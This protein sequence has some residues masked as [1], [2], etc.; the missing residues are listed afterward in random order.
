MEIKSATAA[1]ETEWT[2]DNQDLGTDSRDKED[3]TPQEN[4]HPKAYKRPAFLHIAGPAQAINMDDI[5][6]LTVGTIR[7][8]VDLQRKVKNVVTFLDRVVWAI[9]KHKVLRDTLQADSPSQELKRLVD[10]CF[11]A[12]GRRNECGQ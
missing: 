1:R 10:D 2:A 5:V 9:E 6:A 7:Y 8:P 11:C 12:F 4:L 3:G